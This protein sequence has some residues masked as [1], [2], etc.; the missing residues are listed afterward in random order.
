M[1]RFQPF[2]RV[3]PVG[4][5]GHGDVRVLGTIMERFITNLPGAC[6][7]GRSTS[8]DL[9]ETVAFSTVSPAE[10]GQSVLAPQ[11]ADEV[12]D[13]RRLP[14]STHLQVAHNNHRKLEGL[15]F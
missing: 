10:N 11:E 12:L 9:D 2:D 7:G 5:H 6:H 15:T 1:L 8:P 14:R 3:N 4:M 13:H